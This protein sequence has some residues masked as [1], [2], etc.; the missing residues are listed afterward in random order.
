MLDAVFPSRPQA[1]NEMR[2][3]Y[4]RKRMV[5][6]WEQAAKRR[7]WRLI[8]AEKLKLYQLGYTRLEV[9]VWSRHFNQPDNPRANERL[10]SYYSQG[11]MNYE[12]PVS[13]DRSR[14]SHNLHYVKLH[15]YGSCE[16]K[17]LVIHLH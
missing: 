5:R 7:Y 14:T 3:L 13:F 16:C 12:N 1:F 8:A 2:Y 11:S 10:L 17:T 15:T 6:T 9:H 4:W